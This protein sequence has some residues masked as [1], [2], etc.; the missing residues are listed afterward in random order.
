MGETKKKR[1]W[2]AHGRRMEEGRLPRIALE[3]KPIG[4]RAPGRPPKRW[5]DRW[6]AVHLP[7]TDPK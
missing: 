5:K 1:Y 7:G 2:N 3:G 4:K 6:L